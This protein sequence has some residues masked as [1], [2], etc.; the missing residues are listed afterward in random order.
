MSE[1]KDESSN[2][3]NAEERA[4]RSDAPVRAIVFDLFDTLVDLYIEKLPHIEYRGDLIPASARALHAALPHRS[5]IDF[6]S[7]AST[8]AEV[9][10]EFQ[11]SHYKEG[12]ELSSDTRFAELCDRLGVSDAKLP[13]IMAHV[14]MGLLREQVAMPL[15]HLGLL[16]S[17]SNRVQ[18][19][20]CSNFSHTVT[21]LTILEDYGLHAHLDAIVVSEEVGIR[22]P[23]TEIFE[24]VLD[25]LAVA[26]EEVLHVGNSLGADVAGAAALGIRSVWIT[27]RVREPESRLEAHEGAAPD[28]QID[29]LVDLERI[30]DETKTA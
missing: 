5:G 2:Q 10:R 19:G 15:H 29:D 7:F 12:I 27:R 30:L 13:G 6:D 17:L 23:R 21:A 20:L 8:L 11:K 14:H 16:G 9:D 1:S 28:Y 26:P 25:E 22:K 24:A 4:A 3:A 18:L